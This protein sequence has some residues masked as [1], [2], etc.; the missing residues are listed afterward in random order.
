MQLIIK[1]NLL[2]YDKSFS[3]EKVVY[4]KTKVCFVCRFLYFSIFIFIIL[5]FWFVTSCV[6][7]R[8]SIMEELLI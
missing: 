2:Q 4:D 7:C 6:M 5:G 8:N 1:G 3:E